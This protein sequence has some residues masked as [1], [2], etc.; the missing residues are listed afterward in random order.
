LNQG[1]T[2]A[3]SASRP[4]CVEPRVD[5]AVLLRLARID[6]EGPPYVATF[7][8]AAI[9]P[10]SQHERTVPMRS[11]VDSSREL[12]ACIDEAFLP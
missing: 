2:R 7:L 3:L 10:E 1:E 12:K 9:P 11:C 4:I 5:A 8:V 6:P